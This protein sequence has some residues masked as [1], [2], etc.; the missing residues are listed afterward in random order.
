VSAKANRED[1]T[2][3]DGEHRMPRHEEIV[4]GR[5]AAAHWVEAA[6]G[7]GKLLVPAERSRLR[8]LHE[9]CKLLLGQADQGGVITA[10]EIDLGFGHEAV[11]DDCR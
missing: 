11:I 8:A 2:L 6:G 4:A 5:E 3:G 7:R 1:G 9:F 10:L